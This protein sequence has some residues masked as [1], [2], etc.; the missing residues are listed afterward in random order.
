MSQL[1]APTIVS[2]AGY[3]VSCSANVHIVG[4]EYRHEPSKPVIGKTAKSKKEAKSKAGFRKNQR[5][6][7]TLNPGQ[8][9]NKRVLKTQSVTE[10]KSMK[11]SNFSNNP[12]SKVL[13]WT[14]NAIFAVVLASSSN[15][16]L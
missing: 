8:N 14:K 13:E 1:T 9:T 6:V 3:T 15:Q 16:V 4:A 2:C 5:A 7:Q 12:V 10:E 11:E